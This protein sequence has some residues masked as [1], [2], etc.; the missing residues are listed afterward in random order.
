MVLLFPLLCV[1]AVPLYHRS[2]IVMV[3]PMAWDVAEV[4]AEVVTE[5]V[6]LLGIVAIF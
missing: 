6:L 1:V 3:P 5:I 4:V 2:I